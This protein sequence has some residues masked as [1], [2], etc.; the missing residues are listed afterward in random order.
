LED[1]LTV[2]N[3]ELK[4]TARLIRERKI[5]GKDLVRKL[6]EY[7][8]CKRSAFRGFRE[9]IDKIWLDMKK[10]ADKMMIYLSKIE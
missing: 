7:E 8:E 3:E 1:K 5:T 2:C 9:E 6:E 10:E 4:S